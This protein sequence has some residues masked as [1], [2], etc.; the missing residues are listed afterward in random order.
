MKQWIVIGLCVLTSNVFAEACM[1]TSKPG[2]FPNKSCMQNAGAPSAVFN[3]FCD[4]AGDEANIMTKLE[5]CP[6]QSIATC[7]IKLNGVDGKFVQHVY[8]SSLLKAYELSCKNNM[9]GKG[10]W[11]LK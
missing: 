10:V 5:N 3:D 4:G 7:E 11:T 6:K 8:T 2:E 9:A 1:L